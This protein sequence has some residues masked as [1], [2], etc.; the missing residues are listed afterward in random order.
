MVSQKYVP[1]L[2]H[3]FLNA[4]K[5]IASMLTCLSPYAKRVLLKIMLPG[6]NNHTVR[7]YLAKSHEKQRG[8]TQAKKAIQLVPETNIRDESNPTTSF[9]Q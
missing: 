2:P 3:F 1:L 5:S 8:T 7:S 9:W 6:S 4:G